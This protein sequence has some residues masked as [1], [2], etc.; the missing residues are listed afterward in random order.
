MANS[1]PD[2]HDLDK[3]TRWR[4]GLADAGTPEFPVYAVFL[5]GPE[6]T[7]AHNVFREFRS[8]FESRNVPYEH[9]VI[10]GQHGLSK[11]LHGLRGRLSL[12]PEEI[13]LLALTYSPLDMTFYTLPLPAGSA[14]DEAGDLT[15]GGPW[16]EVLG[17]IEAA[18]GSSE[19]VL[20]LERIVELNLRAIREGPLESVINKLLL[21]LS[22]RG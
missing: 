12:S 17:H 5:V 19:R 6:D 14:G 18:S 1:D 16:L 22:H 3:L 4:Q 13:P 9:L 7:F 2:S 20:D 8:S 21:R 15:D 10:F 11:T